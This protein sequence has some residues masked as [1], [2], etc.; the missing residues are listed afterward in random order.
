MMRSTIVLCM[1]AAIMGAMIAARGM[2][3]SNA[4]EADIGAGVFIGACIVAIIAMIWDT[5]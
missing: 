3:A 4:H 5:R 2:D 1:A